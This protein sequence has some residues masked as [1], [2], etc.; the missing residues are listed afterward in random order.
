MELFAGLPIEDA[1]EL[2]RQMRVRMPAPGREMVAQ[3]EG[4][5]RAVY[6]LLSGSA[7]ETVVATDGQLLRLHELAPG[8]MFGEMAVID[9]SPHPASVTTVTAVRVAVMG[10]ARFLDAV[11]RSPA[12]S[13]RLLRILAR[14]S[15]RQSARLVELATRSLAQR[16]AA[17]LLRRARPDPAGRGAS[18]DPAPRQSDIA[19]TI[20]ARRELVARECAS[21]TRLGMLARDG[22]RLTIPDREALAL[23]AGTSEADLGWPGATAA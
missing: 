5:A 1:S 12:L 2:A 18:I 17:E 16:V 13:L 8:E 19:E 15:R 22:T 6:F 20:G 4:D 3:D 14:R 21:L 7:Q 10:R 23:R 11:T 9:G